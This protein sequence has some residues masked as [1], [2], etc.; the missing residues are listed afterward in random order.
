MKYILL[1]ICILAGGGVHAENTIKWENDAPKTEIKATG[2][3]S[4]TPDRKLINSK[5]TPEGTYAKALAVD[6]YKFEWRPRWNFIGMGGALLPYVLESP[7]QSALGIVET[8]PQKDAQSSS[9]VVFINLYNLQVNNYLVMTGM[10]V[11]KFCFVPFS[12]NIVCLIRSP[13]DKYY[14]EP[15]FRFNTMDTH[16]GISISAS[17]VFKDEVTAFCCS[18]D[19]TRLFAAFKGSDKIRIYDTNELSKPFKVLK[20]VKDPAVLN[21]TADCKRFIVTGSGKIEV[22]NVERDE[23]V[24]EYTINLPQNFQPDKTVLCS[25]DGSSF[26]VSRYSDDTYFYGDRK[27]TK[28][29]KRTDADVNWSNLEQR[30]LIGLPKNST[31]AFY[32]ADDLET[33]KSQF[34]F[35]KISPRT[36][37]KLDKI[38]CLPNSGKGVAIL[39]KLGVLFRVFPKRRSAWQKEIII[40]Q[41]KPE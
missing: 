23:I 40:A 34:S 30:I 38:I 20:T 3:F 32:A 39:D 2:L 26:L 31:V 19:G 24:S 10:D 25:N 37:G 1:L 35:L 27:F 11:R 7:D 28:I 8:L 36:S 16:V 4:K 5:L 9:I 14:P 6:H 33:P 21:C 15:K 22:F 29:C 17:P 12:S 41:P 13:Y 18:P